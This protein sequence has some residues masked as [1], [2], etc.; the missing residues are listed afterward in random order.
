MS[1]MDN[2]PDLTKV[3]FNA[4]KH[5]EQQL[6]NRADALEED[7]KVQYKRLRQMIRGV[8][9]ERE[10][11]GVVTSKVRRIKKDG[12]VRYNLKGLLK[13]KLLLNPDYPWKLIQVHKRVKVF[14]KYAVHIS[15]N[16]TKED[17]DEC[18]LHFK[19]PCSAYTN[20]VV[21]AVKAI[22]LGAKLCKIEDLTN[23]C[24]ERRCMTTENMLSTVSVGWSEGFTDEGPD[25]I[26]T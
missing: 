12:F 10:K 13:R 19:N 16:L 15:F 23:V 8:K 6:N 5:L 24:K 21:D 3:P 20:S 22:S 11:R 1:L 7:F 26:S 9:R 17:L 2:L 14:E 25:I 18:N 4:L